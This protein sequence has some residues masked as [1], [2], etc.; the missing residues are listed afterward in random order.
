M[1]FIAKILNI[2]NIEYYGDSYEESSSEESSSEESSSEQNEEESQQSYSEQNEEESQQSSSEQNEEQYEEQYESPLKRSIDE[3]SESSLEGLITEEYIEK[4]SDESLGTFSVNSLMSEDFIGFDDVSYI[5]ETILEEP[6]V[7]YITIYY[8][9]GEIFIAKEISDIDEIKN[10]CDIGL[11]KN[12]RFYKVYDDTLIYIK[13]GDW[14]LFG[15]LNRNKR[16]K[17]N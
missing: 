6:E 11:Y 3:I 10:I 8:N 7:S 12:G 1:N 15:S 13:D 9:D 5:D 14:S 2:F 17:L 4:N 16:Q